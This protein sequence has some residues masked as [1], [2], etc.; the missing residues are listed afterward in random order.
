MGDNILLYIH[1]IQLHIFIIIIIKILI[2]IHI[3]KHN[4]Y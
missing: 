1:K 4:Q 2:R 3:I